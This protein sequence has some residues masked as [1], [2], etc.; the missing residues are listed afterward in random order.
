[1][2]ISFFINSFTPL[3]LIACMIETQKPKFAIFNFVY[4]TILSQITKLS[5]L[6]IFILQGSPPHLPQSGGVRFYG[7]NYEYQFLLKGCAHSWQLHRMQD[8][9]LKM[10]THYYYYI[11]GKMCLRRFTRKIQQRDYFW[12]KVLLLMRRS[13]CCQN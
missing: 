5:S 11:Q 2:L 10:F 4:L 9:M 6:Y 3:L 1:M 13:L 8:V 7:K 12:V